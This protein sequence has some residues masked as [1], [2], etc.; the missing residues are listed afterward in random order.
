MS[1]E[2]VIVTSEAMVL[3]HRQNECLRE[4]LKHIESLC[5][6][7]TNKHKAVEQIRAAAG[8]A[9][10]GELKGGTKTCKWAQIT[11]EAYG[12][13]V[14]LWAEGHQP[15]VAFFGQCNINLPACW[16]SDIHQSASEPIWFNPTHWRPLCDLDYPEHMWG[17]R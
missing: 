6:Y 7:S 9:L 3:L 2:P 4:S 10:I 13:Y 14:M 17:K 1:D 5:D 12:K 16:F 8:R 11:D 15:C